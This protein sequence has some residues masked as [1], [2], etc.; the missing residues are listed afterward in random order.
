MFQP[1]LPACIE[2]AAVYIF[3]IANAVAGVMGEFLDCIAHIFY[4]SRVFHIAHATPVAHVGPIL[5][6]QVPLEPVEALLPPWDAFHL[7]H[8]SLLRP[9]YGDPN[10]GTAPED[11]WTAYI[12]LVSLDQPC[13]Y[14][15]QALTQH[16]QLIYVPK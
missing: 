9:L 5:P 8:D 7:D 12:F 4:I 15:S 2:E 1:L 3:L 16:F 10:V 14:V 11:T 6:N 13:P